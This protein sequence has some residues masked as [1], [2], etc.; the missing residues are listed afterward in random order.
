[1]ITSEPIVRLENIGLT[2]RS[3]Q[4]FFK[5]NYFEALHE[6]CFEVFEG[7]TL[8]IIGRNGCGKSTLFK[9]L[10]GIYAPDKG[11]IT[12]RCN[13]ISL[14]SLS[15]GFDPELSGRSNAILAG[16]FMGTK[17][18][19]VIERLG[20]IMDFSELGQFFDKPIKTYSSGMRA[21]LGFAVALTL[22]AD[23]ILI[24]EVLGVGDIHFR[25]KAESAI[26][27]LINSDQSVILVSHAM[28]QV[29]RLCNRVIWMDQGSV[30][31]IGE[32]KEVVVA[33]KNYQGKG[34]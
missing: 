32:A 13:T 6:V 14:L 12:R 24:D 33:Y 25:K 8:G 27:E 9:I 26:A 1:M 21:R 15:L 5:H 30:R 3:R 23:L 7:E 2:Y 4:S 10:S 11:T 20:Q 18:R 17:K 22:R 31:M 34:I 16:M 28:E 29:R 19:E